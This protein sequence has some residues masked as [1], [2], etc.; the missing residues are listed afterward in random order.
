[1]NGFNVTW[2][3]GCDH[4]GIA[5]QVVVEKHLWES[6]KLT[7]HDLGREK[8]L[9][10]IWKWKAEKGD[11]IYTQMKRMGVALDWNKS[12]FTLDERISTGVVEA[13]SRFFNDGL[14]YRGLY[15][16]NWCSTL[17]SA[18]SDFE[19]DHIDIEG[20]TLVTLPGY[21]KPITFGYLYD[22][23][24]KVLDLDETITVCTTR[25]ETIL[26][27]TAV[28]VHPE[29]PRYKH[30]H[31]RFVCHPFD[32]KAIP[33]ITDFQVVK[34]FG[35]GAVK[36]TPGHSITDFDVSQRHKLPLEEI[37]D[38]KGLIKGNKDFNGMPR[39][40]AR[41][42]I[43][44]HL[45]NLGLYDG[46]KKPHSMKL[47]LCSR[48][49]DVI[50]HRLKEQWFL[51]TR[52]M[53]EDALKAVSEGHLRLNPPEFTKI[54][55]HFLS[56]TRRLLWWGHR[57]PVYWVSLNEDSTYGSEEEIN[58]KQSLF[59]AASS[60]KDATKKGAKALGVELEKIKV[61]QQDTD[62][63]D[64]WFSSGLLPFVINGWP[65]CERN[66]TNS[67]Q[68]P[69]SL[70]ETG[71]DILFFWVSR[72]V[73]MSQHL[74]GKLPFKDVLLHGLVCDKNG[75]KMSKSKGN[76]IDPLEIIEG[77]TKDKSNVERDSVAYGADALR[78]T[79]CSRDFQKHFVSLDMIQFD[80]NQRFRNKMWQTVRLLMQNLE[81]IPNGKQHMIEQK[82]SVELVFD[83]WIM[84]RLADMVAKVQHGFKSYEINIAANGVK[85]FWYDSFC[86]EACKPRLW[87][88]E[89]NKESTEVCLRIFWTS[90]HTG[91][92]IMAPFMPFL[93]EEIYQRLPSFLPKR[94]SI[95]QCA[96]PLPEEW[97]KFRDLTVE[98]EMEIILNTVRNLREIRKTFN[99]TS[100]KPQGKATVFIAD[101]ALRKT[102][103]E[104]IPELERLCFLSE[105]SVLPEAEFKHEESEAFLA[106]QSVTQGVTI[107][108][109]LKG[110]ID[111]FQ[112]SERL[113]EKLTRLQ[114]KKDDLRK[115][116]DKK[117][118]HKKIEEI[119]EGM[120]FKLKSIED[121][122]EL[123]SSQLEIMKKMLQ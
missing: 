123:V 119:I 60:Q 89:V 26:G 88:W 53:T 27:D 24:Y 65:H 96:Y 121:E 4:A 82:E 43:L 97:E 32:G 20:P 122:M 57:I 108:L 49:G 34:E 84:S 69:L 116:I 101:E 78:L 1:M 81:N 77:V 104:V 79:L 2:F 76:V 47:P 37:I 72:M 12:Y 36:V 8:F 98:R 85:S 107:Q 68:F 61:V 59:V 110:M 80:Y 45:S 55:N 19:V 11:T 42:K 64:T 41:E 23:K 86:D 113:S 44:D 16:I 3:P 83:R 62:V 39:F 31:G 100:K 120:S 54:W 114:K 15:M 35:T 106:V 74:T 51:K 94:E 7:R 14:I 21:K 9:E 30:L 117:R 71:H 99:I 111:P 91:L 75:Q 102:A 50:E 48:S 5:T 58:G 6:K 105:I 46:S 56:D 103:E 66:E 28:M 90:C 67:N 115:K 33:I 63:L 22:V 92:L 17:Q 38:D 18:I 73:M 112:E 52:K 13:F 109:N 40:V 118:K 70:M 29:D 93:T 10:E 95:H 25:P 87:Q